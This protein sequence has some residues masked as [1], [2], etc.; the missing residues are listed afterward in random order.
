VRYLFL[1]ATLLLALL[2]LAPLGCGDRDRPSRPEPEPVEVIEPGLFLIGNDRGRIRPCGCSKPLLGGL[3]RRHAFFAS[4]DRELREAS[5]LLAFG[6][7]IEEGGRQQELKAESFLASLDHLGVRAFCPA[8]G[9]LLLGS[10]WWRDA[11]QLVSLPFVASNLEKDGELLFQ[12]CAELKWQGRPVV[13]CS[14]WSPT[15]SLLT[16]PGLEVR[17]QPDLSAIEEAL[18]RAGGKAKLIVYSNGE[19][20]EALAWLRRSGLRDRAQETLL[21][22]RGISDI[23][24]LVLQDEEEGLAALEMGKKGRD[25]AWW[26]GSGSGRLRRYVL[27]EA[28]GTDPVGAELINLY[29]DLVREEDLLGSLPV[30]GRTE[31]AFAGSQACASCHATAH[32]V[33]QDSGHAGAWKTLVD[34][35]DQH[36]PECVACHVYG[37]GLEGG[38]DP[39]GPAPVNVHCESCHG[40]AAAHVADPK[41]PL[42][43]GKPDEGTCHRCHDLENSPAFRFEEYWPRI[44]HGK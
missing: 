39:A 25:V 41:K 15:Q 37:F 13:V 32:R 31:G 33:W 21:V 1:S 44:A 42:A 16:E 3:E 7:L 6:D 40:A 10:S 4:L 27:D 14:Y 2:T 38:F 28:R 18:E 43:V 22:L 35:G 11:K 30:T 5:L 20:D 8:D 23:P 17:A 29:R 24:D 12:P 9:D 34:S 19:L 26:G 36:D